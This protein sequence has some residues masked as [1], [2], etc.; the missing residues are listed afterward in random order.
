ML[1]THPRMLYSMLYNPASSPGTKY[2]ICILFSLNSGQNN[3]F[4][5][6]QIM[7]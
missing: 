3:V 6:D 2:F 4:V 1:S 5:F 7:V